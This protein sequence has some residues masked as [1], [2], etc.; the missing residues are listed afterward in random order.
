[1]KHSLISPKN[2]KKL[3]FKSLKENKSRQIDK[4]RTN[5]E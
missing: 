1:M 3:S 2:L 4:F 5:V